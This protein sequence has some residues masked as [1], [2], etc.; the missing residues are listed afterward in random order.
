MAFPSTFLDKE[1]ETLSPPKSAVLTER[2][3]AMNGA[4][5]D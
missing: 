1:A 5:S 2:E 3:V 4:S